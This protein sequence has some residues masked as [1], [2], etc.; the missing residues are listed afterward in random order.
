MQDVLRL[1]CLPNSVVT[2]GHLGFCGIT[3]RSEVAFK[4]VLQ[5]VSDWSFRS[6]SSCHGL[7]MFSLAARGSGG[8]VYRILKHQCKY[9]LME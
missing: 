8:L 7:C 2:S 4:L 9:I 5:L 1:W 3:E 6:S